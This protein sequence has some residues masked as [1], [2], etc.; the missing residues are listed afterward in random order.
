ER[1]DQRFRLLAGANRT[2]LRRQQ[3]LQATIDW[4]YELLVLDERALLR[5]LAVFVGGWS[6]DAAMEVCSFPGEAGFNDATTSD[7]RKELVV[8]LL[9]AEVTKSMVQVDG[10]MSN[11]RQQPRYRLLETIRQYA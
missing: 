7:A 10:S 6:L 2:A 11:A 8:D 3:T 9:S 4:S 1:L 5:R